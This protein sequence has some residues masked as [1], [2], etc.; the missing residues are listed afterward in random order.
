MLESL[1]PQTTLYFHSSPPFAILDIYSDISSEQW[2]SRPKS[3]HLAFLVRELGTGREANEERC[4][5]Q[6]TPL[7]QSPQLNLDR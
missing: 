5:R 6:S 2:I 3:S 1:A 7:F 4:A